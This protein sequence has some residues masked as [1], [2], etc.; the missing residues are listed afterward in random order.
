MKLK[1]LNKG[2]KVTSYL[3]IV[4]IISV[5]L[6]FFRLPFIL[7]AFLGLNSIYL[8]RLINGL[9]DEKNLNENNIENLSIN[10]NNNIRDNLFNLIYP[11]CM[12]NLNGDII[13]Y[14]K[15]FE[16]LFAAFNK[17]FDFFA[18]WHNAKCTLS[19]GNER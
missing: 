8:G 2:S 12:L 16:K 19:C 3:I 1:F 9:I 17:S 5:I 4:L 11:V 14:N 18:G 7:L 6:A 13:W 10:I 15:S